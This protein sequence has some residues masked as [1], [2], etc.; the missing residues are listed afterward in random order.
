MWGAML[1]C[2]KWASRCGWATMLDPPSAPTDA[3][4]TAYNVGDV[5]IIE[6]HIGLPAMAGN[7]PLVG[8]N[9]A[10]FGPRFPPVTRTYNKALQAEVQAVAAE[11]G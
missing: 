9:D 11:M 6:D 8:L 2:S 4:L 1:A 5:M 7:H 10:R 3:L